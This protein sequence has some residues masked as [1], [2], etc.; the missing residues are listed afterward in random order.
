MRKT[1]KREH[2]VPQFYLTGFTNEKKLGV[3]NYRTGKYYTTTP[4]KICLENHLYET[5][6]QDANPKLGKYVLENNIE[7]LFSQY[8]TE[9][10]D[11]LK[12]IS[13]LCVP[14]QNPNAL[15]LRDKEK[16]VLLRLLVNFIVRHPVNMKLLGLSKLPADVLEGEYFAQVQEMLNLMGLGGAKSIF[17]AAQK[18]YFLTEGEEIE[19]GFLRKFV[20]NFDL[21][22]LNFTFYYAKDSE[23]ITS[24]MP[25]CVGYDYMIR[26]ENQ[27]CLYCALTP[28][29]AVLF[30]NYEDSRYERNRMI[31]L[32]KD[33]VDC[34]NTQMIE[35]RRPKRFLI[36]TSVNVIQQYV[37][38]IEEA[39]N[40]RRGF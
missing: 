6:W 34:F 8:E 40:G 33:I 19:G 25:V 23:F 13:A 10:S 1:T 36:A 24:D 7:N 11:L 26:G 4:E 22:N 5:E 2:Y 32:A 9:F 38:T 18:K 20:N 27:T 16:D 21:K 14:S 3:Y 37:S 15:I 12:R 31:P 35:S 29:V 17:L 30:G 39:T 28:K